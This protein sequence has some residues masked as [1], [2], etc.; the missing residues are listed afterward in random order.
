MFSSAIAACSRVMRCTRGEMMLKK[1]QIHPRILL[2]LLLLLDESFLKLV[3]DAY[4]Q[5]VELADKIKS[6]SNPVQKTVILAE[7]GDR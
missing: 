1:V 6:R 5:M 7:S 4:P 3:V 2:L